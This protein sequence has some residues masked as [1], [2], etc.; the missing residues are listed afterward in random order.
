MPQNPEIDLE[1]ITNKAKETLSH[2]NYAQH[3]TEPIAF[4]LK[5]LDISFVMDSETESEELTE[6]LQ[7][8]EGVESVEIKTMSLI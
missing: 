5:A 4:G 8:I 6:Q 2:V 7:T 1:A 3:T